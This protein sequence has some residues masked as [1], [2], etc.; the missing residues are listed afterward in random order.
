MDE[1]PHGPPPPFANLT[2][3]YPYFYRGGVEAR[4]PPPVIHMD[5]ALHPSFPLRSEN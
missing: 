3:P 4:Y 2:L 5:C 1:D